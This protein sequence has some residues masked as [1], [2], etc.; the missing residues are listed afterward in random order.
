MFNTKIDT[1]SRTTGQRGTSQTGH[2]RGMRRGLLGLAVLGSLAALAQPAAAEKLEPGQI[3]SLRSV[4]YTDR[5]VR[6]RNFLGELTPVAKDLDRKDSTFIVRKG[7]VKGGISLESINYPGRY[8]RHQGFQIKLHKPDGSPLFRKD[9]TFAV[10]SGVAGSGVSFESVNYPGHYL[11]HCSFRMF[12]DNNRRGNRKCD[13]TDKVYRG[14][15]SFQVE[16][17]QAAWLPGQT[18]SLRSVNY[19]T[20]FARHR[21]FMGQLTPVASDLDRKDASFIVRAGM[22]EGGISL[23]SVN[24]PGRYLRHQGFQLKLH[25]PDRSQLFKKD[26]TFVVR[27]G[28]SGQGVS[29][30]SSNYPGHYLRHCSFQ[31]FIDNNKRGNR[32]CDKTA[33]VYREDVSF[34][35]VEGRAKR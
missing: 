24:F 26:A 15:V 1:T 3:I 5:Y 2:A 27:P 33:R 9:A 20:R 28:V 17:G 12:I 14:D 23:E 16:T 6:H 19:P 8:L 10:R 18:I 22:V 25:K 21:G 31:L 34:N 13:R 30:E 4:N 32:K 7:L 35:V 29:L 11:R